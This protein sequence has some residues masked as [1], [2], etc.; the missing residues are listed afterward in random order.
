MYDKETPQSKKDELLKDFVENFLP[1]LLQNYEQKLTGKY[2]T[3]DVFTLADIFIA[4]LFLSL[5]RHGA[6]KDAVG[7]VPAVYCPKLNAHVDKLL[8]NELAEYYNNVF[9]RDS[10]F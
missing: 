5:F 2:F 7:G 1:K 8:Q 9:I 6:L 4:N 10:A 3:G